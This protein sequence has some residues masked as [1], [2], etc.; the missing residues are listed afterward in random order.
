MSK[1]SLYNNR[2]DMK[3]TMNCSHYT[4]K[5]IYENICSERRV[6]GRMVTG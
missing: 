2:Y 3:R 6:L 4:Y 1:N 5:K